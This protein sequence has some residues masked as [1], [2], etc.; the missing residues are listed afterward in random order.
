MSKN[1]PLYVHLIGQGYHLYTVQ[2]DLNLIKEGHSLSEKEIMENRG[3][4][5]KYDSLETHLR[6]VKSLYDI[7]S[8]K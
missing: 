7:L 2:D 8:S 4:M 1:S 5:L 3:I 6:K